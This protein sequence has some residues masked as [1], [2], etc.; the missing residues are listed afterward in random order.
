[1]GRKFTVLM[2]A[3]KNDNAEDLKKAVESVSINQKLYPDEIVI[4]IDGPVPEKLSETINNLKTRIPIIRTHRLNKNTGLG[5]ALNIGINLCSHELIARMDA[6][7]ISLPDR[8]K[9]QISFMDAH[10]DIAVVG[11]QI[12]EFIG[13]EDNIVGYR[14]VPLNP[15]DCR[16]YYQD[17]DPLNHMTVMMRKSAILDAGNY[18]PWH[19]DEDTY[20]W[21][22]L[23][24][25]GYEI[26]NLPDVLVNVRVGDAMYARRG[27]W[28][29]FKSDTGILKWKLENGLTSKSRF[30]YN[31]IVRFTVQVLM[32]NNIRAWFFKKMLRKK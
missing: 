21:G 20:L 14:N 5:N 17:R 1:M 4:I 3:Y 29:Y 15:Q 12:S 9:K 28:K 11:G 25:K 10:P 23:L 7:D 31:Y 18:L 19:L 16:K 8:F 2:S 22:R 13:N 32:P 6:D 27:G 30:L 24:K 26:A